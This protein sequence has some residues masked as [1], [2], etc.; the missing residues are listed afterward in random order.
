MRYFKPNCLI[1]AIGLSLF[2]GTLKEAVAYDVNPVENGGELIGTINFKGNAPVKPSLTVDR[3]SEYCGKTVP[4]ESLIINPENKGI[5]NVVISLENISQGKKH[6]PTI[7]T[8]DNSQCQFVPHTLAVM[9]GDSYELKSSDPIIHNT[10]LRLDGGSTFLN[11]VLAPN[12]NAI[13][14]PLTKVG[15]INGRCDAHHFMT[16]NMLVFSHPYFAIT[17]QKGEFKISDIPPGKYNVKIWH[18]SLSVQEKEIII[19][20]SEKTDLSLQLSLKK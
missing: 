11:I 1:I 17:D 20:P 15:I 3:N 6:D 7:V 2:S 19:K 14:R 13:K 5:Q 8:L 16:V 12:G 4:D 18:E 10:H 9:V